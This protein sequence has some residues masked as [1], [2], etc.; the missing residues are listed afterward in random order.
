MP[1]DLLIWLHCTLFLQWVPE[2]PFCSDWGRLGQAQNKYRKF[3]SYQTPYLISVLYVSDHTASLSYNR[4]ILGQVG[5]I[6]VAAC[7]ST[8]SDS[9]L[10]YCV[11]CLTPRWAAPVTLMFL[12]LGGE[13]DTHSIQQ[14]GHLPISVVTQCTEHS[15][16]YIALMPVE[17]YGDSFYGVEDRPVEAPP[18]SELYWASL[19]CRPSNPGPALTP[20][21]ST[22]RLLEL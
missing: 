12:A 1:L 7:P 10:H 2:C 4:V 8:G 18:I 21:T 13:P 9:C 5:G 16:C 22:I 11:M 17:T 19:R 15:T 6:D 14:L 20:D 3:A